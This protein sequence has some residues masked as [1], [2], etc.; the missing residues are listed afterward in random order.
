VLADLVHLLE[1]R[2]AGLGVTALRQLLGDARDHGEGVVL[3]AGVEHEL[4]EVEPHARAPAG[5]PEVGGQHG[6]GPLGARLAGERP[7][8]LLLG[9]LCAA[10]AGALE[11]ALGPGARLHEDLQGPVVDLE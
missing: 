1:D 2:D 4:R 7:D 5:A 10:L 11:D 8:R 3:L 9:A 6:R